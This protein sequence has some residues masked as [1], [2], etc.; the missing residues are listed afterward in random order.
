M[1]FYSFHL[2]PPTYKQYGFLF[3]PSHTTREYQTW[4][5]IYTTTELWHY[6]IN[7]LQNIRGNWTTGGQHYSITSGYT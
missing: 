2:Q 5:V 6:G 3:Q 4:L 1:V 7:T